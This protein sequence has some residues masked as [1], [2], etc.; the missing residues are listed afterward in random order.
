MRRTRA[1]LEDET[2]YD[3]SNS[4]AIT[5]Y[6]V[7]P[8]SRRT[9]R[10]RLRVVQ[11]SGA[12][13][14]CTRFSTCATNNCECVKAHRDCGNCLCKR[15][16]SNQPGWQQQLE[17][18]G[19][20]CQGTNED[21]EDSNS[22]APSDATLTTNPPPSIPLQHRTPMTREPGEE[23][24]EEGEEEE[25][26]EEET[27]EE[28]MP[29]TQEE[30]PD[31]PPERATVEAKLREV[32][33]DC[34]HPNDGTH[35]DG[36]I[37]D[38]A[39]WQERWKKIV[40]L[41]PQRYNAPNG[42]V[43]RLFVKE[44][45]EELQGVTKRRWNSE[46]FI[47][48]QA[49]ILQRSGEVKKSQ[50]IRRRIAT[51]LRDWKLGKFDMLVQ[52]TVRTSISLIQKLTRGETEAQQVKTFTR[53]VLQGKIRQAVRFVTERGLG[54]ALKA[55]DVVANKD[56]TE[57]TVEEVLK[58]KH[59]E[60]VEPGVGVLEEYPEVPELVTLD[61]TA[62]TV[63]KVAAKLSG[64]AGPGGVDAMG[65][66]QW[67]LKYGV[68]STLLREAVAEFTRW[69]A[70]FSPPWAAYR[71]IMANRLIALDKCPG[72]RPV[73][74]GEIWRRIFAKCVIVIAGGE[75]KEQC[76]DEQ[77]CAGLEAGIEGGIH[78]ARQAWTDN[79]E[80]EEWGFLLVDARN[81][82]NEGNR[83]AF[84][85]T[86]RHLWPSGARFTYNCYK[87]W[88]MLV[89]R[90]E[91][92]AIIILYSKE[93][94]TQ[95]DPLAMIVYGVGM[96]PLTR[97]LKMK[98][99][100]LLH[101]WYADDAAAGGKFDY[102]MNYYN[103]LC[104]EGPGRGYFPEPTK[105]ILVVK[106]QSVER[107]T[108]L[109]QH[110]GFKIVTGT[111]Y[112]GGH[113][114]DEAAC[115]DWV[116]S[117][118]DGWA[119]GIRALSTVARSSPQCAFAGLQK[120][121]QSEWMHLQR[122]LGG[123]G[124]AFAPVEEAISK[125]F[126]PALLGTDPNSPTPPDL[127]KLLSL[128]VKYAGIGIPFSTTSAECHHTTSTACTSLLTSSL[129]GHTTFSLRDHTSTMQQ[130]RSAAKQSSLSRSDA[131]LTALTSTMSK[132]RLRKI[133]R[134]RET[135]AWLN[136]I[137]T[138]V[139]GMSLSKMEFRDGLRM[140]YG[141]GLED[142]PSKCDG[143][144][145]KF[146]VEHALACKQGGLVVG[147]HD[148]IKDEIA[149]LATMATSPN[150]VRDE[151]IIKIGRDTT[152]TGVPAHANI[153][154]SRANPP[155]GKVFERGDVLVHGLYDRHTSC[156]IDVRVTDT[157]QPSY[158]SSTPAKA[159]AK[160]ER[161]KKKQYLESCL[162]ERRHFAPYVVDTYG[163]LGEEA[164]A[165][166]KRIGSMLAEKWK[167]PYSAV[168]GFVNARVSIAILRATHLCLR[169]SRVPYRHISTKRSDWDDGAG[170]GMFQTTY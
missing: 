144:G 2:G 20:I 30:P 37:R 44:V 24:R 104:A 16:C 38:D 81:A 33:G 123:I 158:L 14:S 138:I 60:A 100:E 82:F 86:I 54:G 31:Q 142:L 28:F 159:I 57:T 130:G 122:S 148:E 167:S 116:E 63:A 66:Q 120:S 3:Q 49:V 150:R 52:D 34:I 101:L 70:N 83:S 124:S 132:L 29:I 32:Y 72:V 55:E 11:E 22:I 1:A 110:L 135:G 80:D 7:R 107:A 131:S 156:I 126:L 59:P 139:N 166:N 95:G 27:E 64:A 103:L 62:D 17:G 89:L 77:L 127:R 56:G 45:A 145:A 46:R 154:S 98:I 76:G 93:G 79:E 15:N 8:E 87:H 146:S 42:K 84:L 149:A 141:I 92:G 65:L 143:C 97:Y 119:K 26:S 134:N 118:V 164:K 121:L 129:L 105:S 74:I 113:I 4:T 36:G 112:L 128:P 51:R 47:V 133:L 48:F 140:R 125:H 91:D 96:L 165:F 160:Q 136:V 23:P 157:D 78:A 6:R 5:R 99:R 25:E 88:T 18:G 115:T 69:M 10:A 53:M 71:A 40:G 169:G 163:L 50:D 151:P 90:G 170:L 58:S 43:G 111:R 152:G 13:C 155:P 109:F 61:V 21:N 102:I 106:P 153:D 41:P 35:L 162:E 161:A 67:L 147:R 68:S 19:E 39:K 85:W 117:K 75:A 94:V 73:G 114:G 168:M 12:C 9:K 137:P 108:A